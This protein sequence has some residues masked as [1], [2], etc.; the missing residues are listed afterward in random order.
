VKSGGSY[1]SGDVGVYIYDVTNAILIPT[2][3]VNVAQGI[4]TSR[5][6]CT[7]LP[8]LNST[9]YRL[10]FHIQTTNASAW[11]LEIDNVETQVQQ[12]VVGAAIG[13][14]TPFTM[15]ITADTTAPTRGSSHTEY[16]GWRRVGS[17]MEM[18]WTYSQSSA[19]VSG[20]GTYYF[21]LPSGYTIDLSKIVNTATNVITG[22]GAQIGSGHL[23][24][25][26]S[27]SRV[28]VIVY[29]STH[30]YLSV[31]SSATNPLAWNWLGSGVFGFA[32]VNLQIQLQISVPIA[33]WSTNI[34]LA[35]DFTEYA[36]NSSST[37]ADD[38]TSFVNGSGGAQ[39]IIGVTNLST[40]RRKRVQFANA[41]K[42]TDLTFIQFQD[43]T[44]KEWTSG[45]GS[46]VDS[47]YSTSIVSHNN[48]YNGSITVGAGVSLVPVVGNPFQ[49]DVIFDTYGE[50]A[51]P[52]NWGTSY[53]GKFSAFRVVKI[54]NGN[55]AEQPPLI[56]IISNPPAG[57]IYSGL[58]T[59]NTWIPISAAGGNVPLGAKRILCFIQVGGAQPNNIYVRPTGSGWSPGRVVMTSEIA[60]TGTN[61]GMIWIPLNP[62]TLSFDLYCSSTGTSS[63]I[64][65]VLP[66][67][68]SM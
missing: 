36:S 21:S 35:T 61:G 28:G 2:S 20:S 11:T 57:N 22:V 49:M 19:G 65:I 14:W 62:S 38:T 3:I 48:Y 40:W 51:S 52:S 58:P 18:L 60:A 8:N 25:S 66:V 17:N 63:S 47:A 15:S 39:G 34:N 67:E 46:W 31:N 7:W 26:S 68:Y 43:A 59:T 37:D 4:N 23:Y 24:A 44:T 1:A 56:N 10:I 5:W 6:F 55:M 12:T 42:P 64:A 33:Q 27:I 13:R 30:F 32:T 9:S 45:N 29:D 54:S 50:P 16:A 41:I 53:A